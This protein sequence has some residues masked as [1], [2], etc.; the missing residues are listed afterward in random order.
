[1]FYD[2]DD[3]S[4]QRLERQLLAWHVRVTSFTVL[5]SLII[6]TQQVVHSQVHVQV[7]HRQTNSSQ[8]LLTFKA[9]AVVNSRLTLKPTL[10]K[11]NEYRTYSLL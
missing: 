5:V 2:A 8:N 7:L 11:F 9:G 3:D 6:T 1:M 4:M 10:A